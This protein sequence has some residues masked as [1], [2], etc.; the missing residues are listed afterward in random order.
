M[1]NHDSLGDRM[2][3]YENAYR[4]KLI[5]RAPKVIR[6]DGKAF[7]T[8]L[9][10]AKKPFDSAVTV[11]MARA[12]KMVMS[13]IGGVARFAYIQSDECSIALND[14]LDFDTQAWFDNNLQKMVSVSSSIFTEIFNQ[15][16]YQEGAKRVAFF[17]A[18]AFSLPDLSELINYYVW[19]QQDATRN[20]IRMYAATMFSH[21]ELEG[22]PNDKAQEMMFQKNGFNWNNADTWTKRGIIVHKDPIESVDWD[23][24]IFTTNR[25]YLEDLYNPEPLGNTIEPFEL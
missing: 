17:D 11:A 18:R 21:H 12:A 6:L 23:I 9:K 20:S 5:R 24:P 4:I 22:V 3:Q 16:Y 10:N 1:S 2:K 14:A 25:K 8:F 19:R 15:E 13:E 7:H